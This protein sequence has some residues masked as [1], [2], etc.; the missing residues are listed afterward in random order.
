MQSD[1]VQ[2]WDARVTSRAYVGQPLR[3]ISLPP[4]VLVVSIRRG[5]H[6]IVPNGDT[7]LEYG[8][9]LTLVGPAEKIRSARR[10]LR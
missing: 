1:E 3:Q 8:D 6:R 9:R 7:A 4:E 10:V 5:G 2:L